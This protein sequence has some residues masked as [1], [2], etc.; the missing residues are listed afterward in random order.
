[1]TDITVQYDN[2][3]RPWLEN[4]FS[5]QVGQSLFGVRES[6][7]HVCSGDLDYDSQQGIGPTVFG[8]ALEY[9]AQY[10]GIMF[11]RLVDIELGV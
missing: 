10:D 3:L 2:H 9:A 4:E 6:R 1:M 5:V 11:D 7:F 8:A